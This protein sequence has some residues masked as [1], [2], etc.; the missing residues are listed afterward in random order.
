MATHTIGAV[1]VGVHNVLLTANTV[2]EFIFSRGPRSVE[3]VSDG[4]EE[5]YFTIDG[6]DPTVGGQNSYRMPKGVVSVDSR[7][8]AHTIGGRTVKVISAGAST[9]SVQ[10]GD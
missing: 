1:E 5:V 10:K 3:I 7:S 8:W 2:E 6:T 9:V 4:V